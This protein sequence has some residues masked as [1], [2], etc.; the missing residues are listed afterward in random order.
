MLEVNEQHIKLLVEE[1]QKTPVSKVSVPFNVIGE[2]ESQEFYRGVITGLMM[3]HNLLVCAAPNDK[4]LAQWVAWAAA[5]TA[6]MYKKTGEADDEM[7]PEIIE[8]M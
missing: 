7:F 5:R 6:E 1:F 2:D 3:C 8:I 4:S